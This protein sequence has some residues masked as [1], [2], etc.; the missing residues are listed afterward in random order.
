MENL[1]L[2]KPIFIFVDSSARKELNQIGIGVVLCKEITELGLPVPDSILETICEVHPGDRSSQGERLALLRGL[3]HALRL[4]YQ[5]IIL[6]NDHEAV[7]KKLKER[8]AGVDQR[9]SKEEE[10]FIR[11][12]GKAQSLSIQRVAK[13]GNSLAHK[14]SRR[15]FKE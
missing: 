12:S 7:I 4:G 9:I 8:M 11:M 2:K 14:L 10:E 13:R 3:F 5:D 15:G 1:N 6:F